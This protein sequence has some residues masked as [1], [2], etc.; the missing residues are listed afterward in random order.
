M[1]KTVK[2]H[3]TDVKKKT[4][5]YLKKNLQVKEFS[6]SSITLEKDIWKL[7]VNF[8]ENRD[9][10]PLPTSARIGIDTTSGE[11]KEFKKY[12]WRFE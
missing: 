12:F 6:I 3:Y 1:D 4:K 10:I 2:I 7:N 9:R 11:V 8:K 5:N